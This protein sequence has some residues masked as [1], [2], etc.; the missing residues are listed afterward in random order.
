MQCFPELIKPEEFERCF[1]RTPEYD[2]LLEEGTKFR[3]IFVRFC[4]YGY[5][6]QGAL[7]P[8]RILRVLRFDMAQYRYLKPELQLADP[9]ISFFRYIV[10]FHKIDGF[11]DFAKF[12]LSRIRL[13]EKR[14]GGD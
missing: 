14:N 9:N 13:F 12:Y 4:G 5:N 7:T 6:N 1:P 2:K 10:S 8:V 11:S 3:D